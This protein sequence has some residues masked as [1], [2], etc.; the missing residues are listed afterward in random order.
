MSLAGLLLGLIN[1]ALVVA[2][3]L[4]IGLIILW[5]VS[6]MG[7]G[8]VPDQI[9][10]VYIA[11]VALIGLYLIVALLF[12][13]PSVRVIGGDLSPFWAGHSISTSASARG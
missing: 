13:M 5:F 12:G 11:I 1:A 8:P 4:L 9:R 3:L 6:W 10:K 7:M 2:V